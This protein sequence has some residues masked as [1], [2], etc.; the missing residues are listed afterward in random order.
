MFLKSG[1]DT[2][3]RHRLPME[4]PEILSVQKLFETQYC[5]RIMGCVVSKGKLESSCVL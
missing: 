5:E 3:A 2:F 4:S 1:Y